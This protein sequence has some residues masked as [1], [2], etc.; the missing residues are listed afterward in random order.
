[1]HDEILKANW[2]N[3]DTQANTFASQQSNKKSAKI[4]VIDAYAVKMTA[5]F[6]E[7]EN[8][9]LCSI[10][11]KAASAPAIE[12]LLSKRAAELSAPDLLAEACKVADQALSENYPRLVAMSEQA[13][14][15][16]VAKLR[17][18]ELMFAKL[19]EID[20]TFFEHMNFELSC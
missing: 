10:G 3:L 13:N 2:T 5:K 11:Y 1:M 18:A 7:L 8:D 16:Q 4:L 15:S 19:Q 20:T 17:Y 6:H 14:D 9:F 12:N